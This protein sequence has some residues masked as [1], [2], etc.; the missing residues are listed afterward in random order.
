MRVLADEGYTHCFFVAGGNVMHLL[1]SASKIFECVPFTH[2]HSAVVAAE[3]FNKTNVAASQ[4]SFSLVTA[5]PGLTNAVTA[6]AGSWLE[7]RENLIIGGQVKTADLKS[8]ELRQLGIQEV[9]GTEIVRQITKVSERLSEP[10]SSDKIKA[11][12]SAGKSGRKGPVFLE[13][14]WTS[15]RE[16]PCSNPFPFRS[17]LSCEKDLSKLTRRKWQRLLNCWVR[18]G[19]LFFSLAADLNNIK[20]DL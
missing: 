14:C 8:Q 1:D 19:V 9:D 12:L 11:F 3:Y 10:V 5:G 17:A 18:Q 13:V 16:K 7:S 20:C 15:K 4:R 2:E 6:I